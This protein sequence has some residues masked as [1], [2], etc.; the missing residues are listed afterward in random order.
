MAA[1]P[2]IGKMFLVNKDGGIVCTALYR[3]HPM[4]RERDIVFNH[5]LYRQS[6]QTAEGH[7]VYMELEPTPDKD[8]P[9]VEITDFPDLPPPPEIT[10]KSAYDLI[11]EMQRGGSISKLADLRSTLDALQVKIVEKGNA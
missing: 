6:R 11:D 10:W 7:W 2:E 9:F 8:T 4:L 3:I 5:T 1:R